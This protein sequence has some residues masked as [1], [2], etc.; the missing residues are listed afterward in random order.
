MVNTDRMMLAFRL[1]SWSDE[2]FFS[3]ANVSTVRKLCLWE[4]F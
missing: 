2:N 4:S 3:F 1:D